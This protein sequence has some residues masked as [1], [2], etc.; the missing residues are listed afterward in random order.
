MVAPNSGTVAHAA[1]SDS[2]SANPKLSDTVGHTH[3]RAANLCAAGEQGRAGAWAAHAGYADK[4]QDYN[5]EHSYSD[6]GTQW[7]GKEDEQHYYIQGPYTSDKP[8]R[9]HHPKA[10]DCGTF[11]GGEAGGNR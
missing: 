11:E 1:V 6:K 4:V 2:S 3:C 7:F 8:S 9:Q 10:H 5:D